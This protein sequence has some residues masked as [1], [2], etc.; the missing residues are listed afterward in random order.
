M[1][2]S[3]MIVDDAKT[4]HLIVDEMFE[5]EF[6][7]LHASDLSEAKLLLEQFKVDLILLDVNLKEEN[8]FDFCKKLRSIG[9]TEIPIIF[10]TTFNKKEDVLRAFEVG[11]NDFIEKPFERAVLKTRVENLLAL[12]SLEKLKDLQKKEESALSMLATLSH[13][14]I[15]PLTVIKKETLNL[16]KINNQEVDASLEGIEDA[17]SKIS[18]FFEK[19]KKI[20][21]QK[22]SEYSDGLKIFEVGEDE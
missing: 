3:L 9:K 2:P 12:R 17:V 11:G 22:M 19:A 7:L 16:K 18:T 5:N 8:G 1:K 14:I 20:N 13:E 4:I 10:I 6:E 21:I 15:N